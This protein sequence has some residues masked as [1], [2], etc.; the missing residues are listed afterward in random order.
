MSPE[1]FIGRTD[2]EAETPILWPPD[3][4]NWLI[5]K[6]PDAGKD[7]RQEEKGTTEDEMVGW[8]HWLDGHEFEQTPVV[9]DGQGNRACCIHGVAE[10]DMTKQ[11]NWT[12]GGSVSAKQLKG[13]VMCLH[14]G[15]PG[16]CLKASLL[17]L[18]CSPLISASLLSIIS[19]CLNLSFET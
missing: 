7:W 18:G 12:C 5:G 19:N 15:E 10:L 4:R 1:L 2:A 11:L 6:D 16:P 13:I 8:H 17:F 3:S 14:W 9:G